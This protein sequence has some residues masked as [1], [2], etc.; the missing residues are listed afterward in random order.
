MLGHDPWTRDYA[1]VGGAIA[2]DGVGY[3]AS[4]YGSMGQMVLGLT[5]VLPCGAAVV[6]RPTVRD[7][8]LKVALFA[9]DREGRRL[10]PEPVV[11]LRPRRPS[12]GADPG[13]PRA[14]AAD[15]GPPPD[16]SQRSRRLLPSRAP[17]HL[18][19]PAAGDGGRGTGGDGTG[20]RGD[21]PRLP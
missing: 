8:G 16:L 11:R 9:I 6:R 1:T 17:E 5:L 13:F 21:D 10:P 20:R 2:P 7:P 15:P 3:L 18:L 12:P 14:G 19:P 4:R